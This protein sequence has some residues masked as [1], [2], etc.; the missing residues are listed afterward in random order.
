VTG[1]KLPQISLEAVSAGDA[2]PSWLFDALCDG[3]CSNH[4]FLYPNEASRSQ[5]LHRLAELSIPVD[6][7]HHLTLQRLIPLMILDLGLPPLLNN[8]AGVFLSIH[9]YTKAAAEAGE[10]PLMFAPQAQRQWMPY[11]T[12]RILSLHRALSELN[13]PWSWDDDPGAKEFDSILR[14]VSSQLGGTHPHHALWQILRGLDKAIEPPF[15]L[16]DVEGIF[17]MDSAPDYTEVERSF[18]QSISKHRPIHQLCVSGSF[19]LG[20]HGSYLVEGEWEY[21]SQESLPHWVPEHHVLSPTDTAHWRSERSIARNTSYHRIIVNRRAHSIDAAFD[22]LHHYRSTSDGTVAIIDGAADANR[23]A[24]HTRLQALGYITGGEQRS[25]EEIPA[26]SSLG[27]LMRIGDGLEAW[28]LDKMRS[29]YEHQSLPLPNGGVPELTHPSRQTWHPRPHAKVLENIARSFH[30]RGGQGAL[31]RWL[32]TLQ[33]ATPQMGENRER[34]LQELEETQWWVR[35]IAELWHPL[36]DEPSRALLSEYSAGCST[37]EQLPLPRRPADGLEWLDFVLSNLNWTLLSGRTAGF[38]R[39][40]AGLQHLSEAHAS[41]IKTLQKTGQSVPLGGQEFFSYL[42]HLLKFTSVPRPRATGKQIQI[43][44]PEEAQGIEADVLLLVGL[45]VGSWSM[46]AAKVPWLDAPAKLRLG[47]LHSDLA[48]RRGRHHL[49]HLLNCAQTVIVFDSSMEEGGG[50]SAPLAEWFSELRQTGEIDLLRP[51]PAFVPASAHQLGHMNRSWHWT[52]DHFGGAWL[53]PRPFTMTVR[54]GAI[55]AERA[56]SRGRDERQRLGL[57]LKD[58]THVSGRVLSPAGVAMAHEVPIQIDRMHRQPSHKGLQKNEYLPWDSRH[59]L[60]S[61]DGLTLRP[62]KSQVT[63]GSNLAP[64]WPHL[65]MKGSR[66]TGP[67]IDPRPLPAHDMQSEI[68]NSVMGYS[69]SIEVEIWSPSR[70]Q[71]WLDCPRLAW[72]KNHL[73]IQAR[74]EQTED[75]DQRTRG[76]MLHDA[77]AA[78]LEA[79]GVP[80]ASA[81]VISPHP[82]GEGVLK[83][84]DQLWVSILDFLERDVPWLTRNDAVAVHRCREM[85]GVTPDV[86]RGHLEG[87]IELERGGRIGRM[88]EA[89]FVLSGASPLACEFGIGLDGNPAIELDAC[90]DEGEPTP[91]KIRGRIDRVDQVRLPVHQRERAIADGLLT[92]K[93]SSNTMTLSLDN[94]PAAD[95]LVVIR[96]LKTLNGPKHGDRGNRH[97]RGLF[98]EVQL[99]LYARAWELNHPGDRVVGIGVTEIGESTVHYLELDESIVPYLEGVDIGE[100]TFHT[101]HLHR[102]PHSEPSEQNGF[103]AFLAERLRTSSRAIQTARNGHVNATPGRHYSFGSI[104]HVY[105]NMFGG[106]M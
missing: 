29:L 39:S 50:P 84:I 9:T 73:N 55:F 70:I 60:L 42:D 62:S 106:N 1:E 86:W 19:R 63:F 81:P 61:V 51:E 72:M 97:R 27:H 93:P 75:L 45:D 85:L 80:T 30:V 96:D 56:G 47:M 103:R 46:K 33:Q 15:T 91:F 28:S 31:R 21:V 23:D 36:L 57:A 77:E 54:D 5:I 67:A 78:L 101:Q 14:H 11:Q 102:F 95:R 6:T 7:T 49:R 89:D 3:R 69:T 88:L 58:G 105:P 90:S 65:G 13:N 92:P 41:T 64:V 82:L 74:E 34:A 44:T 38:D 37:G 24:W 8:S 79:H 94:P 4:M 83:T 68:L 59:H 71:S 66:G 53:T 10:L 2:L 12:E 25:L 16:N 35:C 32:A 22:L 87:E 20:H 104:R 99:G 48:I 17:V 98:D 100:R 76:T 26:L 40:V 43:L 18:L 52:A